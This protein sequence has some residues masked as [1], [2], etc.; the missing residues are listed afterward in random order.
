MYEMYKKKFR[1]S[2]ELNPAPAHMANS[3]SPEV[4]SHLGWDS[5]TCW[6]LRGGRDTKYTKN[7]LI[8][9]E[10]IQRDMAGVSFDLK[11]SLKG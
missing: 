7:R 5:T 6:P 2:I 8:H 3:V 11:V 1:S 4:G 9:R 10:K